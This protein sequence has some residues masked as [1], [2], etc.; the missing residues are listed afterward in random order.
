MSNLQVFNYN[1]K[2]V[3]TV[4]FPDGNDGFIAKDVCDILEITNSKDALSRLDDDEKGVVLT[5]TP[6]GTQE[7]QAVTESGL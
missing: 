7:M 1:G 2:P 6:G 3:R 4:K 5:D